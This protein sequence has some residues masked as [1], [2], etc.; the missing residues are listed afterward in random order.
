[1]TWCSLLDLSVDA[2]AL[3]DDCREHPDTRAAGVRLLSD[4]SHPDATDVGSVL[5]L[6]SG[7]PL[8]VL[9]VDTLYRLFESSPE[10]LARLVA[11]NEEQE[12]SLT[13]QHLHDFGACC[14][15]ERE[16]PLIWVCSQLTAD[17]PRIRSAALHA[18]SAYG[19]REDVREAVIC[20]R[21]L[22]DPS[23]Q[24]RSVVYQIFG[25]WATSATLTHLRTALQ[26]KPDDQARVGAPRALFN[27]RSDQSARSDTYSP[28]ASTTNRHP[29]STRSAESLALEWVTAEAQVSQ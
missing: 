12:L 28:R 19:W 20:D 26:T 15:G 6:D 4:T 29:T 13:L 5:L 27:A 11:Q 8:S 25:N 10:Q 17:S 3:L 21:L 16:T 7:A 2:N 9:G 22:N 18:L 24:V 23:P 1:M 14:S